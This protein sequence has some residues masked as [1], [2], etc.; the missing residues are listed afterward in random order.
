MSNFTYTPLSR[1]QVEKLREEGKLE[2]LGIFPK[3]SRQHHPVDEKER[4]R[5]VRE[6]R[7]VKRKYRRAGID[8]D[9]AAEIEGW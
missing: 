1:Q 9:L 8:L 2:H 3:E 6:L 7:K 5:A 4:K